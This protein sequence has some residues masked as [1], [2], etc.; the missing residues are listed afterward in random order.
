M[1][2]HMR[3]G[4]PPRLLALQS[5]LSPNRRES[6]PTPSAGVRITQ[7]LKQPSAH[8]D[9]TIRRVEPWV[10][11]SQPLIDPADQGALADGTDEQRQRVSRDDQRAL[12]RGMGREWA[13]AEVL[14]FGAGVLGFA[15]PAVVKVPVALQEGAGR[16]RSEG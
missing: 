16:A 3:H 9:R 10:G 2:G 11:F 15:I 5:I 13:R 8:P 4:S 7:R 1:I 6:L 12:A 14:W